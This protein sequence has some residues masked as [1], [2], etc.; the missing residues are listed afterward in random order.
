MDDFNYQ[1]ASSETSSIRTA[2]SMLSK[3]TQGLQLLYGGGS[4]RQAAAPLT[5]PNTRSASTFGRA[6]LNQQEYDDKHDF[7]LNQ[8][9]QHGA[10]L[11]C[12]TSYKK[13]RRQNQRFSDDFRY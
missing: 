12:K 5:N 11:S 6:M 7:E 2:Y 4:S 3:T 1:G 10:A 13:D 9:Q 8:E